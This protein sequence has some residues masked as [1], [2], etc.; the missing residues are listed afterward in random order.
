MLC[1]KMESGTYTRV[2]F[3]CN[4]QRAGRLEVRGYM[5]EK[6]KFLHQRLT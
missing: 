1:I 2:R 6:Q 5:T 4:S 3:G